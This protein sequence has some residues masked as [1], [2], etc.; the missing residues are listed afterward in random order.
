VYGDGVLGFGVDA[1]KERLPRALWCRSFAD[2]M[3]VGLPICVLDKEVV[4]PAS[5]LASRVV[6]RRHPA[7]A[8]RHVRKDISL[9]L[10]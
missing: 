7:V 2:L 3:L 1:G 4:K 6:E 9:F 8:T 10:R 5:H